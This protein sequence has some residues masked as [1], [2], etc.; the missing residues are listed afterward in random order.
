MQQMK[1]T[2]LNNEE[3][4]EKIRE[5]L[6]LTFKKLL[7][8]KRQNNGVLVLSVNGS[9]KKIKASDIPD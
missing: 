5:G 1:K 4:R 6:D 7:Q 3:I 9:I 8:S 2:E